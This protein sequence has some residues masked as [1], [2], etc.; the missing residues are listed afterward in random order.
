MMV[1]VSDTILNDLTRFASEQQRRFDSTTLPSERRERG[2]YGTPAAIADFMG[3]MFSNIPGG[4]V[5]IL[6]PGAGVGILA[7]AVC[8]RVLR[9]KL[10]R[11]LEIELWEND[12]KLITHLRKTMD[13]CRKTLAVFGHR[14][15]YTICIDDF[16]LANARPALFKDGPKP[17][18]HLAIL[19]PPYFKLRKESPQAI[20]MEHVVHGQP[21]IYALFMAIATDLLLPAGELVAITPRSY[22]NGSY[23]KKFR[24]WFFD[25]MMARHIHMFESRTAAFR[26][27]DVLQENVILL[28][29]KSA[30]PNDVI[31]TSNIGRNLNEFKKCVTEYNR[32]ID[33]SSGDQI[34]RVTIGELE[35][36]IVA[37][38]D[39]L[40]CRF[41]DLGLDI[42]TGP[43]VTFRSTEFLRNEKSKHT[44]PLL[45][46]HNVR[47]FVVRFPPK[48]GKPSHITVCDESMRI[49]LPAKRYVLLKRFTAKEEDR[50][51]VAGI[52]QANESYS[53]WVG[54]ENHLNY[55]YRKDA[56]LTQAEAFGIAAY[57]N[58]AL[59]DRYFR[60]ISGNTQVNATEIRAMPMPDMQTLTGIGKEVEK[61]TDRSL[62]TI[63]RVVGLALGL[64]NQ[65]IEQ[66]CEA[67]Q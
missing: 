34:V 22:F 66:L 33:N 44:A 45:W 24:R 4:T 21:N 38:L 41:R 62:Q 52:M 48:N 15:D 32:V 30:R 50:R 28:A 10:G 63:E 65:L 6:D 35:H 59:V 56:E 20:A 55:V 36:E 60:A 23:F 9:E 3:A 8:Q 40:P 67:P 29:E 47:P 49:L 11:L 53:K 17:S 19:N 51:L 37:A 7:A 16:I 42:S 13:Y 64:P 1:T 46:M 27:D 25:R 14:L 2:H 5:R 43:V 39:T 26:D 31:L 54:L 18:F 12:P 61:A 57:F 58:S